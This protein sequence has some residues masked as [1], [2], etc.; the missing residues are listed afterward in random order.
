ML[1][2]VLEFPTLLAVT[3]YFATLFITYIRG[4]RHKFPRQDYGDSDIE[5]QAVYRRVSLS[6]T[7]GDVYGVDR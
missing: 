7:Q 3:P 6:S 4:N 1:Q 5:V 2:R